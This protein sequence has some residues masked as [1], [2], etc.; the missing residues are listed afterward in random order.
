[1]NSICSILAIFF[2]NELVTRQNVQTTRKS[3]KFSVLK[4]FFFTLSVC[5][6]FISRNFPSIEWVTICCHLFYL[7]N[8]ISITHAL[9]YRKCITNFPTQRHPFIGPAVRHTK[10]H[11]HRKS[12]NKGKF[13]IWNKH[14][15]LSIFATEWLNEEHKSRSHGMTERRMVGNGRATQGEWL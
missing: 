9:T 15:L 4:Q 5:R 7:F 8:F 11:T 3:G 6:R 13:P 12:A 14:V 10:T 1:M 2:W